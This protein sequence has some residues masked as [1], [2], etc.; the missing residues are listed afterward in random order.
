MHQYI[1]V[2]HNFVYDCYKLQSLNIYNTYKK[3]WG[4]LIAYFP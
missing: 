1:H 3:F 2:T 4:E